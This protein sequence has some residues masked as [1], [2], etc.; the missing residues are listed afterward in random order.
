MKRASLQ[1]A[2]LVLPL[3]GVLY[4]TQS[5]TAGPVRYSGMCDAS[6]MASLDND[7]FAVADDELSVIRV[8]SRSQPGRSA[9]TLDVS[10]FLSIPRRGGE[11]DFEGAARVQ[12]R[13]YWISSHG[14]N[15][16]GKEQL[17]R[18]RFFATSGA[19]SNGVIDLGPI[20]RPYTELLQDLI[21]EP[22]LAA[23]EL[24]NASRRQPKAP[25]ALNI[26]GLAA[27][28]DGHLLI[29]FRN[30]I[31]HGKALLVPLLNPESLIEGKEKA[32]FGDPVLLDLGGFG[33]RSI[34][35]RNGSYWIA[36]G[37]FNGNGQSRLYQ[38]SGGSDSPRPVPAP[39]IDGLNPEGITFFKEPHGDLLW[40]VSDDGT[41]KVNGV[42]SKKLK[43]SRLKQFRAVSIALPNE[44]A[45][46]R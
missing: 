30:P 3:L 16:E 7:W 42:E 5:G 25:G 4:L 23:F 38:W 41:V 1:V 43:D 10:A 9:F 13:I 21:N 29:G 14:C 35:H 37:S 15:A 31:P 24:G 40:V 17:T 18:R 28:P 20:G 12:D 11:G 26:E 2:A 33:I 22:R 32:R 19:V 6:A 46:S 36:A 44:F 34:E 45:N 39:E 27:T 8:Y